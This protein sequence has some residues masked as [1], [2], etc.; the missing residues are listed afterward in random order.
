MTSRK[1]FTLIEL[2]VVIAIIA[3]LAAILFPV[4]SRAR[5]KARQASCLNNEKQLGLG[6]MMYCQDYD[7]T[8]PYSYYYKDPVAGGTAG[9]YQWSFMIMPYVKNYQLF[10]CPSHK[11]GG[12]APTNPCYLTGSGVVDYQAPKLSYIA[13][14]ALMGRA[15]PCF[16]GV[17]MSELD[18]ASQFIAL[19]EM[20]DNSNAI[21]GS[22]GVSGVAVKSHRPF[23]LCN[24]WNFDIKTGPEP[25]GPY[26]QVTLQQALDSIA[27]GKSVGVPI[28]DESYNHARYLSVDRHNGGANYTF[29]DGH[30]K[31][32]QLSTVIANQY[33]GTHF[34]SLGGNEA[35]NP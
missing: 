20:T 7:E 19:A 35:I 24:P 25:A 18:D 2:L 15:R 26:Q 4:F 30:A 8:Y 6:L 31:W 33:A 3:I 28:T 27:Y 32:M 23:N 29:A 11:G 5:E 17:M 12:I 21:G 22:S 13:N 34:Y 16:H 10:V 14:E 1:G 9:Y